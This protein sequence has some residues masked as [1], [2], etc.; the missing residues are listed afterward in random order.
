MS[1]RHAIALCLAPALIAAAGLAITYLAGCA[2]VLLNRHLPHD[3]QIDT[4]Y[5]CWQAY[6]GHPL[7][8][9]RLLLALL[10]ATAAVVG[11]PLA[12]LAHLSQQQRTLHGD[13][14]WASHSEIEDSGL[15]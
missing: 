10:L 14:R 4:W 12:L 8:H 15:L 2:F 11:L 3:V 7:L 5:R 13:A 6:G 9:K 1:P